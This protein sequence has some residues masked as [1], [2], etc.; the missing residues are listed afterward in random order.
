MVMSAAGLVITRSPR[1]MPDPLALTAT[2]VTP[3]SVLML[4]EP[5]RSPDAICPAI[6][7]SSPT[8]GKLK[9]SEPFGSKFRRQVQRTFQGV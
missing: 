2:E 6:A 9:A 4:A 7:A 8:S 1:V 3:F 5:A